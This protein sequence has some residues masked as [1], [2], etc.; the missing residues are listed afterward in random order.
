M[1]LELGHPCL[2]SLVGCDDSCLPQ[3]FE[4]RDDKVLGSGPVFVDH[5]MLMPPSDDGRGSCRLFNPLPIVEPL[6][7]SIQVLLAGWR[8]LRSPGHSIQDPCLGCGK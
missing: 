5:I 3:Q 6:F 7:E 8:I 1:E 2:L 4:R